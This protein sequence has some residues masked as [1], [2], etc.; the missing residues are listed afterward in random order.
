MASVTPGY[1][2][3][4]TTDPITY[5][6]LNL[7]AQPTVTIGAGEVVTS[8]LASSL[9][10]TS[11][12]VTGGLTLSS[13]S[14]LIGSSNTETFSGTIA[15]TDGTTKSNT[16]VIAC[17][18][19]TAATVTF[20]GVPAAGTMLRLILT[21]DGTGGNVLTFSTGFKTTGTYTLTTS[22]RTY[23]I[24]FIS[25]GTNFCETGRTAALN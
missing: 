11:P 23:T 16:R 21:T 5:T 19:S 15:L 13:G 24:G 18:S 7:I 1:S 4:G 8:M 9:T 14:P 6:K 2:F 20:T 22:S 3:T 17:T 12:T 10:L 25:D